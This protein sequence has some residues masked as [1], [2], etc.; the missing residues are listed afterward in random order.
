MDIANK[1]FA[2]C[3]AELLKAS[4]EM[5]FGIDWKAAQEKVKNSYVAPGKQPQA[6]YELYKQSVEFLKKH[7]LVTIPPLAEED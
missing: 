2:W 3:D 6:M 5:G 1:E 4:N 7:D